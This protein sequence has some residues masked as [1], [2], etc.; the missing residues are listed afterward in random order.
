ML[1]KIGMIMLYVRDVARSKEFYT[2][3][4]NAKVLPDFASEGFAL[5]QLPDSPPLALFAVSGGLPP[6]RISNPRWL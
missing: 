4:L 2:R 6:G 3:V 1:F 5:L